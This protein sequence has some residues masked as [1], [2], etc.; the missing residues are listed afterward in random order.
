MPASC[1]M[2]R[3]ASCAVRRQPFGNIVRRSCAASRG[4]SVEFWSSGREDRLVVWS[5]KGEYV[6]VKAEGGGD[7]IAVGYT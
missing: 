2:D 1:H 5:D 3:E 7:G 6:S 4:S